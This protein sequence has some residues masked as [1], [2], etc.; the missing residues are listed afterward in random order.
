M[1]LKRA[2]LFVGDEMRMQTWRWTELL[3]L[4]RMTTTGSHV[5]S[6]ALGEVHHRLVDVLM[7]QLVPDGL[8]LQGDFQL[9]NRLRLRLEFT[10]LF[11]H[12][13]PDVV[14]RRVHTHSS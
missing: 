5:D 4:L 7:W 9:I 3:Q 13:T 11:Q 6:Q 12:D 1:A 14:V 10:I 2:G 8:H